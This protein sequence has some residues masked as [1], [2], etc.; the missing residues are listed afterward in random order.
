MKKIVIPALIGIFLLVLIR[1][2]ANNTTA[3]GM[4]AKAPTPKKIPNESDIKNAFAE[5]LKIYGP[6]LAK[7]TE[8][9]FRL[10]TRHFKS[11]NFLKTLSPGMEA[12]K[13]QFPFGWTSLTKLWSETNFAPL[14][15]FAQT[16]NDTAI[17]KSKGIKNY[18]VFPDIESAVFSVA[19]ILRKRG[20]KAGTW[21]AIERKAQET[22]QQYADKVKPKFVNELL[23]KQ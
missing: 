11:G 6:D 5:V 22:Y 9:I 4:S 7:E 10:E 17:M 21:F 15:T 13:F 8:K 20:G 14:G 19:E 18:I 23:N 1:K 2:F 12:T 3:K 16:E